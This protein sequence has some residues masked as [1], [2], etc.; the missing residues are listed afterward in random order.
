MLDK[1]TDEKLVE[2][3]GADELKEESARVSEL[4][5]QIEKF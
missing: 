5:A 1:T 2:A 4:Q 3:L